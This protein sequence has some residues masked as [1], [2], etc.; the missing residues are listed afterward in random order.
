MEIRLRFQVD[1]LKNFQSKFPVG[2]SIN[3]PCRSLLN[4]FV[5]NLKAQKSLLQEKL[6]KNAIFP[7]RPQPHLQA[8]LSV[9]LKS[10]LCA[11]QTTI[12]QQ[13]LQVWSENYP[14]TLKTTGL[15]GKLYCE[16]KTPLN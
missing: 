11:L 12:R 10:I 9:Y 16:S 3:S 15:V 8:Q 1:V 6:I 7:M 2:H 14:S 4:F 5:E 13:K